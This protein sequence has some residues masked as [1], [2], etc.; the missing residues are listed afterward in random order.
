MEYREIVAV[1]GLSGL[2]QLL[3]TK[4]DGAIV[5]SLADNSTK[6][7]SA[8]LH[9]ITPLESIEIYTTGQNVRLH[10]VLLKL[11]TH[12]ANNDRINDKKASNQ[13]FQTFFQSFFPEID[14][15]RVYVSDM[16][17]MLK[18]YDILMQHDLIHPIPEAEVKQEEVVA[19]K[20]DA[21]QQVETPKKKATKKAAKKA[22]TDESSAE[23]TPKKKATRKKKS[24][25]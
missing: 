3:A 18:W 16:K 15:E 17:K 1:T 21:E 13:E 5:K 12:L 24:E 20:V 4:S 9:N 10:D 25:E 14:L 2:Y 7:I 22:E 6:F 23:E 11:K 8:R 19:D